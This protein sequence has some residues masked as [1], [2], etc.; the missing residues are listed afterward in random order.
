[1]LNSTDFPAVF[2]WQPA[3]WLRVTGADAFT[4]LQ[5]QFTNDLRRLKPGPA[6][7]GLW[8]NVKGKVLADSFVL[9]GRDA[10]EIWIG[11]YSSAA[12]SIRERLE[13]FI[14]ADDVAIEDCTA[15]WQGLTLIG[16]ADKPAELPDGVFVFP[17]R[18]GAMPHLEVVQPRGVELP[19]TWAAWPERTPAAM[20]RARIEAGIPLVPSDVGPGDLPNEGGLENDA[21]SYNK[22]CYLGQEVMAR[23]HSMGKVRR[24]LVRVAANTPLPTLPAPLYAGERQVGEVRT[25]ALG[26]GGA[27]WIGLAMVTLLHVNGVRAVA[28]SPNGEPAVTLVDAS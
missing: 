14:I 16:L 7:Y 27:D 20:E 8:L 11:S 21:I 10:H 2:R 15:D 23:L 6:V 19:E 24:K 13:A 17:G 26:P 12:A 28:L 18:R 3:S 25:A 22:G 9:A 5:G 1:V 4:F